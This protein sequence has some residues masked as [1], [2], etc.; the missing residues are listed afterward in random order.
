[1]PI[2]IIIIKTNQLK[3]TNLYLKVKKIIHLYQKLLL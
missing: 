3:K 2:H 1:M